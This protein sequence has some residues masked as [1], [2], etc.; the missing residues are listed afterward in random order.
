MLSKS[1]F[2][3]TSVIIVYQQAADDVWNHKV[4]INPCMIPDDQ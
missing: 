3:G 4:P 2:K 1:I